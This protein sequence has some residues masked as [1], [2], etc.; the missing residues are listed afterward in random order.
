MPTLLEAIPSGVIKKV[1]STLSK[2]PSMAGTLKE[3]KNCVILTSKNR[4]ELTGIDAVPLETIE[5]ESLVDDRG[6][7]LM[8]ACTCVPPTAEPM[9]GATEMM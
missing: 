3:S 4:A 1:T 7:P 8:M 6:N 5:M 2:Y 9:T